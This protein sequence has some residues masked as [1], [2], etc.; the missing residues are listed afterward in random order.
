[1]NQIQR[2]PSPMPLPL[3]RAVRAG[4]QLLLSGQIP[5]DAHGQV[6]RGDIQ[7]QTRAAMDRIAQTLADC[8]ASLDQVVKTTVWL[9]SM[10]H[11]PGFNEAYATY[12]PN[13]FPVRSIV[14]SALAMDVDVE[15][16]VQAWLAEPAV[17]PSA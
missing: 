1:M 17:P 5:M 10:E 14:T 8:G 6:V 13:G 16:E 2:Y 3:S 7:T 12:F 15:I 9:S 11:F 4:H